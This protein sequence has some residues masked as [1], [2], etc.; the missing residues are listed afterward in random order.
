MDVGIN[1]LGGRGERREGRRE[2]EEGRGRE[3]GRGQTLSLRG[4]TLNMA[5]KK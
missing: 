1:T 4:M 3:G 5:T 2:G